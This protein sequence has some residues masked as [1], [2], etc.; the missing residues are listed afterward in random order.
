MSLDPLGIG[1]R[2]LD[3]PTFIRQSQHTL[4][5][6]SAEY[7]FLLEHSDRRQV[8]AKSAR[9]NVWRNRVVLRPR[10]RRVGSIVPPPTLR[11]RASA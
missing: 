2:H 9:G 1:I 11:L 10:R 6:R 5:K 8:N 3:N 4:Q 7:T